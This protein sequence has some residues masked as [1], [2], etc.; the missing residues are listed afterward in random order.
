[1]AEINNLADLNK[2]P[3]LLMAAMS[4]AEKEFNAENIMFYFDKGNAQVQYQKYIS[5]NADSQVNL[6]ASFY[7]AMSKLAHANDWSNPAWSKLLAGAK[8]NVARMWRADVKNRFLKSKEYMDYVWASTP[9]KK[10]DPKKAA[11]LLGI[12]DVAKLGKALDAGS[13]GDK[14]T[15]LKLLAELAKEEELKLKAEIIMKQLEEAG[16]L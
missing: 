2:D 9:K 6:P 5:S 1:M 16:M 15:A 10:A 13:K 4:F 8:E 3:N 11:K 12:T 7:E 14:K